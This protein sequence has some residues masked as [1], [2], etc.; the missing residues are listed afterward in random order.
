MLV[1]DRLWHGTAPGV[2]GPLCTILDMHI[3]APAWYLAVSAREREKKGQAMAHLAASRGVL[4]SMVARCHT[5]K[6]DQEALLCGN[7]SPTTS[8][9]AAW[10][11][12]RHMRIHRGVRRGTHATLG[13]SGPRTQHLACVWLT[14]TLRYGMH[15]RPPS[16]FAAT[17]GRRFA[18]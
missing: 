8:I 2:V 18:C 13:I 7:L 15:T 9:V 17:V 5:T 6:G 4:L 12:A 11:R 1:H 14:C 10:E 3:H 16:H